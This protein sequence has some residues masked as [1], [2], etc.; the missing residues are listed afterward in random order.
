MQTQIIKTA[1]ELNPDTWWWIKGDGVDVVKGLKESTWG[2][3]SGDVDLNDGYVKFIYKEYQD[4][5]QSAASI[6]LGDRSTPQ[7][8]EVDLNATLK[9][10]KDD[11]TFL[12]SGKLPKHVFITCTK[13]VQLCTELQKMKSLYEEKQLK[14]NAA[15]KTMYALLW[16]LDELK[17][18][19]DEGRQLCTAISIAIDTVAMPE[20]MRRQHNLA[21]K[22][23]LIRAQMRDVVKGLYHLKRTPATH[24]FVFMISSALRNKK[25]YALPVQCLPYTGLKE[26]DM[27]RMVSALVQEM[28]SQG[29]KVAGTYIYI[30][31]HTCIVSLVGI[32][33]ALTV[34]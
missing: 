21:R 33:S 6:G 13:L 29:M 30:T 9:Q 25:P 10:L 14:G 19:N 27:R 8:I 3:W 5:L 24:V 2:E 11:L 31:F 28:H 12:H 1:A 32:V 16:D 15:E 17:R 18:L 20:M 22:L 4:R 23:G 7:L 34:W 26:S